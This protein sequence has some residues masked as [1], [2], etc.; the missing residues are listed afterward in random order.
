MERVLIIAGA[1]H[2][3]GA[4]RIAANICRFALRDE[5]EFHYLVFDGYENVYGPEIEAAGGK[6]ISVPSPRDGYLQYCR[7]LSGLIRKYR[8]SVVHSHTQFNSG[9]N[10]WI[11]K[12]KGVPIRIAHSHTT[13]TEC[14]VS[15]IQKAYEQAMRY[16]IRRT[17]TH[18]LACGIEAGN[19]MF[20]AQ[21]FQK[22][23]SVLRNGIDV[24]AYLFSEEN[25]RRSRQT[26]GISPDAFVIG[27]AGTLLPLKNQEFLIRLMPRIHEARPNARLLLLGAGEPEERSRLEAVARDCGVSDSVL[28]AGGVQNVHE[29]LS[30]MDVFAFPSLREGT[31]LALLEAQANGLPCI[32]SDRIPKDAFLTDLIVPMDLND[33][34]GWATALLHAARSHPARYSEQIIQQGYDFH[35]AYQMI[36]ALYRSM[37]TV[38]FSFDDGRGDNTA[39]ADEIFVPM[40]LPITLNITTGYVDGSCPAELLPCEKPPM[41]IPDIQRLAALPKVEIAMHGDHHMNTAVDILRGSQKLHDW[42]RIPDDALLGFASPGSGMS[43]SYFQSPECAQLRNHLA[44]MRSGLRITSKKAVRVLCRKVARVLHLP[45]F[46]RIAYHDTIMT[47]CDRKILYSVPVMG[48]ITVAQLLAVIRSCIKRRG[49]LVL[50][51]HSVEAD[52]SQRDPWTWSVEKMKRLCAAIHSLEEQG[53]LTACTTME[54]FQ[55]LRER[56]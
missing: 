32:V 28:F 12:R 19:W 1:L 56:R 7:T 37:G 10:L 13:K 21:T 35:D 20:G 5:F 41:T 8:Y 18:L 54:Q 46:Y 4:E 49:A 50:M 22:K 40:G 30:A 51:F 27:H 24:S 52:T 25:R 48:D 11:A 36:Y 43:I 17:A 38:S 26:Y 42:L 16:M 6:V 3:G 9:L 33:P 15:L 14:T 47:D 34:T 29:L 44:Y 39:A 45:V 2:L 31:P 23:G 55:R 53:L